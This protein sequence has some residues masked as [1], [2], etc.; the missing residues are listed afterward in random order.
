MATWVVNN[1]SDNDLKWIEEY[2]PDEVIV[3]DKKDKNVGM[4]LHDYFDYIVKNYDNLPDIVVFAKGNILQRHITKEELDKII[5]NKTLT[6]LMTMHHKTYMPTCYY[7]DGLYYE[8]NSYWYAG[9][10]GIRDKKSFEDLVDLLGVRNK[11]YLGFSPGAC[12][13]VPK[14]NIF[15]RPKELYEKLLSAISYTQNPGEAH[16]IE[17]SLQYLWNDD[18]IVGI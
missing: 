4:N 10:Y 16:L 2:K 3:Y 17:R 13:I 12:W 11:E 8:I 15:K 14:N 5:G 9:H 6:P 18:I 1:Y 7:R